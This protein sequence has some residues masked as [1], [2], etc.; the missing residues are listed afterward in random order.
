MP[1]PALV[2]TLHDPRGVALTLLDLEP[3]A[4]ALGTYPLVVVAATAATDACVPT[5]LEQSAPTSFPAD[6]PGRVAGRR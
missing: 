4:T 5:R 1:A 3:V 6:K 2:A